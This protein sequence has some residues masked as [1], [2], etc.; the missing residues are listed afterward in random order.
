MTS[1][2]AMASSNDVCH[3]NG[4]HFVQ[5]CAS[6]TTRRAN[7]GVVLGIVLFVTVTIAGCAP[8]MSFKAPWD[9]ST[10]PNYETPDRILAIWSDTVLHE[11][12][13]SAVRGFGGRIFFYRDG[14]PDPVR[15]QGAVAV[16]AFDAEV[17]DTE[18]VA[19]EKKYV[20]TAEQVD[21]HYSRCS[22]G[23]SYSFWIPWDTVGGPNRQ[24]SLVTR[25]EGSEG[26]VVISPPA[27]K[28]LPGVGNKDKATSEQNSESLVQPASYIAAEVRP[29]E[30]STTDSHAPS[31]DKDLTIALPP[32]LAE[33]LKRSPS[34][35]RD[36]IQDP[37]RDAASGRIDTKRVPS[38][39]G[40]HI[41]PEDARSVT[42][43]RA[44]DSQSDPH[45]AQT[46]TLAPPSSSG[47][48]LPPIRPKPRRRPED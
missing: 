26:G 45:Q 3:L 30:S 14:E 2:G 20:F 21:K 18:N 38:E 13:K 6:P 36:P 15:I 29:K 39:Q 11:P 47:R 1:L 10:A 33:R 44:I 9:K 41:V 27:R 48:H 8:V 23:H 7:N 25:F 31:I 5:N 42:E 34:V 40:E 32:G 17:L 19:P 22:L 16:Y 37:T 28:L 4:K 12:G 43:Q 35:T 46:T 24:V